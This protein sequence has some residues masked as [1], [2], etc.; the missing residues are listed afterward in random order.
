MRSFA[1]H[2]P[3]LPG[4]TRP[5]TETLVAFVDEHR[6]D[7]GVEPICK[8]V[9]TLRPRTTYRRPDKPIPAVCRYEF[10]VIR[11]YAMRSSASGMKISKST[12]PV[13]SG[14]SLIVKVFKSPD[15]RPNA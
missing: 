8:V 9:P 11:G 6:D 7:Y 15:A 13:R 14:Y 2:Q 5:P 4:G 10:V 12:V 1:R 3:I